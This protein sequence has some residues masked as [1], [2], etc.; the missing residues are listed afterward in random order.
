MNFGLLQASV[1]V[2]NERLQDAVSHALGHSISGGHSTATH[3]IA[4]HLK[5]GS[6][7]S[8]SVLGNTAK[9]A[10][11]VRKLQSMSVDV[12]SLMASVYFLP[13]RLHRA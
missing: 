3:D 7:K 8:D 12:N 13:S 10:A 5:S 6:L 11:L 1:D 2:G 4:E 9:Q